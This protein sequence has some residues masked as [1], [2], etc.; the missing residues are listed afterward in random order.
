ML[1][2]PAWPLPLESQRA[3][4]P[5]DWRCC[6]RARR[7]CDGEREDIDLQV[8]AALLVAAAAAAAAA[9]DVA[10]PRTDMGFG[11][12]EGAQRTCLCRRRRAK[13]GVL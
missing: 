8:D 2:R 7:S 3:G 12:N 11:V 10:D 6:Y 4:N 9:A 5:V 1:F 13:G